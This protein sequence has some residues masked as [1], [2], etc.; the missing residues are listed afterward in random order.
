M[1]FETSNQDLHLHFVFLNCHLF[2]ET[3]STNGFYNISSVLTK[4]CSWLDRFEAFQNVFFPKRLRIFP[5]PNLILKFPYLFHRVKTG[6]VYLTVLQHVFSLMEIENQSII[7]SLIKM[8]TAI[9]EAVH[10]L[11]SISVVNSTHHKVQNMYK[12]KKF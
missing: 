7:E 9:K 4:Q 1:T 3:F 10:S 6:H 5:S 2:S 11:S 8:V 12:G